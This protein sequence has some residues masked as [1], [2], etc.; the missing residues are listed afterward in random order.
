MANHGEDMHEAR[1]RPLLVR[2][3][4]NEANQLAFEKGSDKDAA[5]RESR[6][7]PA[8]GFNI[9]AV[10][11]EP[12]VLPNGRLVV[13]GMYPPHQPSVE[14]DFPDHD[15]LSF[16]LPHHITSFVPYLLLPPVIES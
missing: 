3:Q 14:W 8:D 16:R 12:P 13:D 2:H 9:F 5:V 7:D 11:P 15:T 4:L 1:L 6:A 10:V